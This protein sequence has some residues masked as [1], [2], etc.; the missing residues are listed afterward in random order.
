MRYTSTY[1]FCLRELLDEFILILLAIHTSLYPALISTR[2]D[3]DTGLQ[4]SYQQYFGSFFGHIHLADPIH[5]S[6][7]VYAH[8]FN[9][10]DFFCSCVTNAVQ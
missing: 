7:F 3:K 8:R 10:S 4:S 2:C 1:N 5:S 6:M 9:L